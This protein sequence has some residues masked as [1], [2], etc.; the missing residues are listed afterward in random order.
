MFQ[1]LLMLFTGCTS[2]TRISTIP[3]SAGAKVYGDGR[4]IGNVPTRLNDSKISRSGTM[5]TIKAEGYED[6]KANIEQSE[7][8]DTLVGDIFLFVPFIWIM[9]HQLYLNPI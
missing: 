9:G 6:Y 2:T 4:Y 1:G 3:R 7:L 5:I 8:I